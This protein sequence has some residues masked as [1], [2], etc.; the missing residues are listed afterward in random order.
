VC[1]SAVKPYLTTPAHCL[2]SSRLTT[3]VLGPAWVIGV[4]GGELYW[5]IDGDA[6]ASKWTGHREA[7]FLRAKFYVL[8]N[9]CPVFK[10]TAS[11]E[12]GALINNRLYSD[13]VFLLECPEYMMNDFACLTEN[14]EQFVKDFGHSQ[15]LDDSNNGLAMNSVQHPFTPAGARALA[16][17]LNQWMTDDLARANVGKP[18]IPPKKASVVTIGSGSSVRGLDEDSEIDLFDQRSQHQQLQAAGLKELCASTEPQQP[19]VSVV[20]VTPG[21]NGQ[22]ACIIR[23]GPDMP[24]VKRSALSPIYNHDA[25]QNALPANTILNP[26]T[27]T[28]T[29]TAP[30]ANAGQMAQTSCASGCA[31]ANMPN[32]APASSSTLACGQ[33]QVENNTSFAN[34]C[35]AKDL[36]RGEQPVARRI[37]IYG[38]KAILSTR[39]EYFRAMF[40]TPTI[41]QQQMQIHI[42]GV[43]YRT[44]LAM[45]KFIYTN[46]VEVKSLDA[47]A[48]LLFAAEMFLLDN[49]REY[50]AR[51]LAQR[52]SESEVLP[53]LALAE[54]F[55]LSQLKQTCIRYALDQ[56][57][58][59]TLQSELE[60][61]VKSGNSTLVCEL[62][63][64]AALQARKRIR[65]DSP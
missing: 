57:D 14:N 37:P 2:I 25:S 36:S 53:I 44:F 58:S 13:V 24:T 11:M 20:R 12:F 28:G 50:C 8:Y 35:A 41:E 4:N 22:P 18:P 48:Y 47:A 61:F 52:I 7:D 3:C 46:K 30:A 29:T 19:P 27:G 38:H 64:Q 15:P 39:S 6:G 56:M 49:L 23:T 59:A 55:K 31:S 45:I 21:R 40:A 10:S 54:R 32:P 17:E 63:I 5:H 60:I 9:P 62:I 26:G 34:A 65:T 1:V 51:V 43:D 42:D 16:P 33:N